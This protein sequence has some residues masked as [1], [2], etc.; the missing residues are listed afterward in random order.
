M[1]K[2]FLFFKNSSDIQVWSLFSI[3]NREFYQMESQ[4]DALTE[5][6]QVK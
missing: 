6:F 2:Y 1:Y 5:E 3:H 4:K